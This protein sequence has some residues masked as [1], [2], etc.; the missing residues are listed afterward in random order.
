MNEV[1][2]IGNI[3]TDI[4]FKFIVNSKNISIVRFAIEIIND[5]QTISIKAYNEM[6]DFVYNSLNKND[7]IIVNGY[8]TNDGEVIAKNVICLSII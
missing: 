4:E 7:V 2:L 3:I 5:Q 6:A 8:L 1:F